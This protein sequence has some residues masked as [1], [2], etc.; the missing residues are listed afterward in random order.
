M[1]E[2]SFNPYRQM[3]I[4]RQ[5]LSSDKNRVAF[6]LG[7]GGPVSIRVKKDGEDNYSPLIEDIAGLT[8]TVCDRLKDSKIENIVTRIHCQRI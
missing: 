6:L 4:L 8:K 2:N 5:A 3:N 1:S 7:A